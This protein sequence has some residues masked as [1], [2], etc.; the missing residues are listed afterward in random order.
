MHQAK[1]AAPGFPVAL[2]PAIPQHFGDTDNGHK[3]LGYKKAK[4]LA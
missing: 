2:V 4:H 3:A 1:A